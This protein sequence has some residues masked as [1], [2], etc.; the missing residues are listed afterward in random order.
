MRGSAASRHALSQLQRAAVVSDHHGDEVCVKT[1]SL[2]SEEEAHRLW[3]RH[4][5]LER[6]QAMIRASSSATSAT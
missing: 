4:V 5:L 2:L 6:Q 3:V 1:W